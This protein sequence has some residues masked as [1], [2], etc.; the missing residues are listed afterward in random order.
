MVESAWERPREPWEGQP[1]REPSRLPRVEDLPL[2]EHGYD[3]RAVEDAFDA[4]YRHAAN[5]D[6]TLRVLESVELFE[7][8]ARDLRTDIRDLRAASWGPLPGS[9]PVWTERT[10]AWTGAAAAPTGVG[11]AVPRIALEAAVLIL[12]PVLAALADLPTA[13]IV[14]AGLAA[15]LVVATFELFAS[16]RRAVRRPA[17]YDAADA[18]E[19]LEL[20]APPERVEETVI[21]QQPPLE[22]E[23]EHV[24]AVAPGAPEGDFELEEPE[25]PVEAAVEQ[26]PPVEGVRGRRGFWR[27]RAL[28]EPELAPV[29]DA[30]DFEREPARDADGTEADVA[31]VEPEP[32]PV[33]AADVEPEP[34]ALVA[35][36]AVVETDVV[37]PE[38]VS[39]ARPEDEAAAVVPGPDH[40]EPDARPG[41]R[42]LD[43]EPEGVVAVPAPE[44]EELAPETQTVDAPDRQTVD[45]GTDEVEPEEPR[46]DGRDVAAAAAPEPVEP[47]HEPPARGWRRWFSPR[48]RVVPEQVPER[49]PEPR[50]V[51]VVSVEQTVAPEQVHVPW[52]A[53]RSPAVD[54]WEEGPVGP[55][56]DEEGALVDAGGVEVGSA[57][58][59]TGEASRDAERAEE[60]PS[61]EPRIVPQ[62]QAAPHLRRGRR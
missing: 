5:L 11:E 54:P 56:V 33:A 60:A 32:E 51:R 41:E 39:V 23:P 61:E 6:A 8:Q 46:E 34:V 28:H 26:A 36:D 48:P 19:S 20:R 57:A 45:A 62:P 47:V 21:E 2:A 24:A 50:H 35:P 25:P 29:E 55:T 44:A 16:T 18:S 53:E 17:T 43:A 37:E 12:V 4:F 22:E 31:E 1:E 42:P 58:D 3:R 49:P 13:L 27:R 14:V 7:R 10:G 59:A 15:F 38:P 40:P 30:A 52:E 9:R